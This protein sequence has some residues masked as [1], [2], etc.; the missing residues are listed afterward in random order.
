MREAHRDLRKAT[1][2]LKNALKKANKS[3]CPDDW[4]VVEKRRDELEDEMTD[5]TLIIR[6]ASARG[7]CHQNLSEAMEAAED[8][9]GDQGQRQVVVLPP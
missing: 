3:Q 7:W 6:K 4:A 9:I 8:A 1:T 2:T 5:V